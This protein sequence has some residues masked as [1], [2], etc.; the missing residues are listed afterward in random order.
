MRLGSTLEIWEVESNGERASWLK[1]MENGMKESGR[2]D[3]RMDLAYII[4][5]MGQKQQPNGQWEK[6]MEWQLSLIRQ[7]KYN[8]K[9]SSETI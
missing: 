2:T 9:E 5:Q 1:L 7:G 8:T 4:I 3:S 6:N